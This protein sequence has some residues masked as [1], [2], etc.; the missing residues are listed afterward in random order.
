MHRRAAAVL[1][2]IALSIGFAACSDDDKGSDAA[3]DLTTTTVPRATTTST[4][5]A[6]PSAPVT[7]PEAAAA[8]LFK[9][10]QRTDRN[11]ASR[12]ARQRAIDA[13]FAHP[14]TGDVTYADQGCEPQG[15]Q[16]ICSWTYPGGALQM[17]V[18]HVAGNSGYVVDNVT[19][20]AD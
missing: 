11:D 15:G 8:G 13:L 9:A 6:A 17:T 18:E 19:Y 12:Y 14:S 10:W 3:G 5:V 1:L 16:F 4:T 2:A 7:S 20:I